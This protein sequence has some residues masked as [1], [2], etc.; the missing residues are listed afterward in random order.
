VEEGEDDMTRSVVICTL[1][2]VLLGDQNKEKQMG[3]AGNMQGVMSN[4]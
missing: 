2:Q 4:A 3:G 1:H